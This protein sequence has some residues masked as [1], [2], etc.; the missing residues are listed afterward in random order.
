M[1]DKQINCEAHYCLSCATAREKS[2]E[3]REARLIGV[4]K[5]GPVPD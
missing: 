3:Q 1:H 2:I 5:G 4:S